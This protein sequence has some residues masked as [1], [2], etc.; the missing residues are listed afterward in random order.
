MCPEPKARELSRIVAGYFRSV[1]GENVDCIFL[2]G[3]YARE[4]FDENSDIDIAAIVEGDR[5]E[6]QRKLKSVWDMA[7]ELGLENDVI[8]SPT[9]IPR[10][11][12]EEYK[13]VLPYYRN[14]AK[15]G[16]KIG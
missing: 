16:N 12:F 10:S 15:E 8:I 4:D 7:A 6:L 3:S 9:V 5:A 1:Y 13:N 14:I 2:Y 11:E